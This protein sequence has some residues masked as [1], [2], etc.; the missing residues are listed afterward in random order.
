[1]R[2][3][4]HSAKVMVRRLLH[5]YLVSHKTRIFIAVCCMMLVALAGAANAYML[6]PVL[7]DVFLK[8]DETLLY[9][10]P[11]ILIALA[12]I[13][14]IANYAQTM[15]MRYVGQRV[16]A[17]MQVQLFD[18]FM[19]ADLGM[20]H[21]ESAG[22]L[23][24][25]FTNDIQ[26]IRHAASSVLAGL[27]KECL[28][29]IVL[30]ALMF[31][32]SWQL[33]I[34][35]LVVFPVAIYP[36]L[37]LGKRM[38]KVA[39]GTQQELGEFTATLDE[40]FQNARV[41]KA[42]GREDYETERAKAGIHR[43]FRLYMKASKIQAAASPMMEAVGSI[44][45]A[46]VIAYGGYQVIHGDNTPGGFFSFI[47]AMIMAYKPLRSVAGLNNQL[48]EGLAAANR[49]F[50]ALDSK[51]SIT[52]AVNAKTLDVSHADIA[53]E[54]VRF[55]YNSEVCALQDITLRIDAGQMVALV[56]ASGSGK[57]TIMNVLM[58]FYD[59]NEG[60]ILIDGQ[61]IAGVTMESLRSYMA[62]VSQ[63]VMLFD[64]TI[65]TNLAYG[66]LDASREEIIEAAT[67]A[68][69]HDFI[70]NLPK[71]YDTRIGPAGVKLSGGQ[72]QRLSIA[73]AILKDTPILLLDEATSALDTESER[74]VQQALNNLTK[75]RTTLVIAH[76][77]STIQHADCIYVMD[78]GRIVEH[79]THADLLRMNGYYARL[80]DKQFDKTTAQLTSNDDDVLQ[81]MDDIYNQ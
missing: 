68:A 7:D 66:R 12:V 28:S 15:L 75:S 35:A 56:G 30:V 55:N 32:Q 38:R 76:R 23:I 65:A 42:Y 57:S 17:D 33:S 47:T 11:A 37:R 39:D 73:R 62:I 16:V 72:R 51:P 29:L 26:M 59:I 50:N 60:K 1:M 9:I 40:T 25:R 64:D 70:M 3:L 58:R 14:G 21:Q 27:A 48:Q 69:A 80:N 54:E 53:F 19:H 49:F 74:L 61:N 5:D 77:L 22:R 34:V 13:G 20:F 67:Q 44:G 10:I 41:V 79:G 4:D 45:I 81:L 36:I 2:G 31:Y 71:G 43:L 78:Q 52:D 6:K 8:K 63:D 24:S 46:A 18:H